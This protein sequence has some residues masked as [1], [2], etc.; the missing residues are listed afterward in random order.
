MIRGLNAH[1]PEIN[2]ALHH[3]TSGLE[4]LP[5][6]HTHSLTHSHTHPLPQSWSTARLPG[7]HRNC[8]IWPSLCNHSDQSETFMSVRLCV[9]VTDAEV[10]W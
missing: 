6:T 5:H 9:R 10:R 8:H 3:R 1:A 7:F 2:Q 4:D